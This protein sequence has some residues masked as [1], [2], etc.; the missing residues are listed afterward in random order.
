MTNII[1]TGHK[2]FDD[3]ENMRETLNYFIHTLHD[4]ELRIVVGGIDGADRQGR[5]Y[6]KMR[7]I[8]FLEILPERKYRKKAMEFRNQSLFELVNKGDMLFAYFAYGFC[9]NEATDELVTLMRHKIPS[10]IHRILFSP[11]EKR[12]GGKTVFIGSSAK[13]AK[14]SESSLATMPGYQQKLVFEPG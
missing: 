12:I 7:G 11:Y 14:I 13:Q 1:V 5:V 8:P 6:A 2:M 10:G 9:G 3:Y 4:P